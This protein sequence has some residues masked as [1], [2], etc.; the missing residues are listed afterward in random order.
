MKKTLIILI[1]A[2]NTFLSLGQNF[3]LKA[4]VGTNDVTAYFNNYGLIGYIK[5]AVTTDLGILNKTNILKTKITI[6]TGL[7]IKYQPILFVTEAD[8]IPYY[9]TDTTYMIYGKNGKIK[10]KTNNFYIQI[11]VG[12]YLI[13]KDL[14]KFNVGIINNI[15]INKKVFDNPDF[16]GY[17]RYMIAGY[18]TLESSITKKISISLTA[19]SD[20]SPYFHS[21]LYG[22]YNL[23]N[24]GAS[25]SIMHK[26]SKR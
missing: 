9:G 8:S 15:I 13:N 26:L 11:P 22:N 21:T 23:Y 20:I 7:L 18:M 17:K 25:L 16:T 5:N 2:L 12:I 6:T 24:Y 19:Y 3:Y 10:N 14:I 4:G 1:F